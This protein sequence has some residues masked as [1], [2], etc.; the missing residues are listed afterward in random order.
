MHLAL[1]NTVLVFDQATKLAYIITWVHTDKHDSLEAA[2]QHG[3]Q[4]LASVARK[5]CNEN[6]PSLSNGRVSGCWPVWS[7]NRAARV[8]QPAQQQGEWGSG[9]MQRRSVHCALCTDKPQLL[10][11]Q[12]G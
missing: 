10:H 8:P 9:S 2:Y 6:A 3:R 12:G 4:Q 1:Y 5:V 11:Q 7:G